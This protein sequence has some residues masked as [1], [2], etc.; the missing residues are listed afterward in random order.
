MDPAR[1][2]APA[3]AGPDR[4]GAGRGR[5]RT[6]DLP[7]RRGP[8]QA[9]RAVPRGPDQRQ[10][11][12]PQRLPL[13]DKDLGRCRRDRLARRRRGDHQPEGAP[14]M[15][16][17]AVRADHEEDLLG[18]VVPHPP[19][20]RR[21]PD[22]DARHRRPAR[23]GAGGAQPLV[24]PADAVPRQP[25]PGR[26]GPDGRLADQEPRERRGAAAVPRRL[27]A[28]DLGA[29][30]D[31]ARP[32]AAQGRG[33]RPLA[34][35]RARL[36]RADARRHRPRAEDRGP[37]RPAPPGPRELRLGA[38][39]SPRSGV[40]EVF[41]QERKGQAFQ[42]AGSI[43]APDERFAEW[44]AR[45]QYGRRGESTALWVVAREHVLPIE[46]FV[47]ELNR[48]YHRVDGYPLKEK[49]KEARERAGTSKE[50]AD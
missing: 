27:R 7:R 36:G 10:V 50:R 39:G 24:G 5:P 41:R 34:L 11:Q 37:T 14:Q 32:G 47:D 15:L 33:E 4:E 19:R 6:A 48:N 35:H 31:R 30:A 22:A 18:G 3:E 8:G 42:H 44:Y 12:V 40:Y 17:R 16:V 21:D 1:A 38:A 46:E 2:N 9:A 45:E 49:L 13:P 23:A 29:R 28:A 43:E 20:P 25:D 26:R